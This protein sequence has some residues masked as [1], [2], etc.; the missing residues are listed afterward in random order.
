MLAINTIISFSP[1]WKKIL[2]QIRQ[3][4]VRCAYGGIG[5]RQR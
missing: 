2:K 4:E 1:N 5:D 3:T